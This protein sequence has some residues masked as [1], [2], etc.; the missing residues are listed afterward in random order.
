MV[1][2]FAPFHL[3]NRRI[4]NEIGVSG[5]IS[6][7][8][9]DP[10]LAVLVHIVVGRLLSAVDRPSWEPLLREASVAASST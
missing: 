5:D 10:K 9:V 3:H 7:T 6:M 8:S 4:L 1:N 2:T